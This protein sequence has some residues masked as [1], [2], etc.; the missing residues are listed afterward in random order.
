MTIFGESAGGAAVHYLLLS[1][2]AEGLFH[3]AISQSG[4]ALNP[5]GYETNPEARA[6]K[7]AKDLNIT[8]TDNADLIRQLRQVKPSDMTSVVPSMVDYVSQ[9]FFLGKRGSKFTDQ[10][11]FMFRKFLVVSQP[12]YHLYQQGIQRIFLRKRLSYQVNQ[13]I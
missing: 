7:L 5:W 13:L 8:F 11:R 9:L 1:P 2:Q 12:H 4:S 10:I 3:K 6:H